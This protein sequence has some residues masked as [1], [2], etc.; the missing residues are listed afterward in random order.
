MA[1]ALHYQV[2]VMFLVQT[3]VITAAQPVVVAAAVPLLFGAAAVAVVAQVA[4]P[5]K[6]LAAIA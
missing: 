4:P 2:A 6:M 1:T 3:K 5:L